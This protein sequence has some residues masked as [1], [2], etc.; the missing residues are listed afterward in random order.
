MTTRVV[1][2][3]IRRGGEQKSTVCIS[4]LCG[5][6]PDGKKVEN[7]WRVLPTH[8]RERVQF[9]HGTD[10]PGARFK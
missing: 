5:L 3:E 8:G 10:F 6:S 4:T 7:H 2:L 9:N 1:N